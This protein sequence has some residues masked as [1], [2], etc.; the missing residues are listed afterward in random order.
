MRPE[1]NSNQFEISRFGRI[2]SLHINFKGKIKAHGILFLQET[3]FSSEVEQKNGKI[4][5]VAIP[6]FL[7]AK[8]TRGAF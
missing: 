7:T 6:S 1:V 3:H 8:Q 5:S 2:Y 4:I